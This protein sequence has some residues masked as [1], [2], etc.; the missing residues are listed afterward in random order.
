MK[1]KRKTIEKKFRR[2]FSGSNGEEFSLENYLWES[3]NILRGNVDA[4]DFKAYIFPLLFYKRISDVYDE[5]FE[6]ALKESNGDKEYASSE[7]NH[8]F[9]IP[10]GVHWNDLRSK[11]KNIGQH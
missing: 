9:Q 11:T 4:S 8:R 5:E 2:S 3:A 7:V 6:Q 10:E 1:T